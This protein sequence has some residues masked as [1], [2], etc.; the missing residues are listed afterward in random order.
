MMASDV[1]ELAELLRVLGDATRLQIIQFL[2]NGERTAT[3]IV[4][5]VDKSQSTISQHLKMLIN[6]NILNYRKDGT[7]KFYH[8][9]SDEVI[10][11]LREFTPVLASLKRKTLK[12]LSSEARSDTLS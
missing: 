2:R 3:E 7:K 12:Q 1:E 5:K 9:K 11:I 4:D 10:N 6:A 8:I